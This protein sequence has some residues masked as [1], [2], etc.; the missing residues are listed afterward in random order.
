MWWNRISME[1]KV[2]MRKIIIFS[3]CLVMVVGC[4]GQALSNRERGVVGGAAAGAGL[5]AIIGA[6]TGH[7]GVGT[8]IGGGLGAITG[9]V[10]GNEADKTD[11]ADA[12][13]EER[14]RRQEEQLRQQQREIEELKRQRSRD[15]YSY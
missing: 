11:A 7:A 13:R 10:I 14:L 3:A 15:T 6:A 12:E 5:G 2:D 4:S 1:R 9:G 8:A